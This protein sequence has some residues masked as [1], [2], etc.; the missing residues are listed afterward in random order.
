MKMLAK[1]IGRV[2]SACKR[3]IKK[4]STTPQPSEIFEHVDKAVQCGPSVEGLDDVLRN[5][6]WMP[7]TKM[8]E[9][10]CA[11][12]VSPIAGLYEVGSSIACRYPLLIVQ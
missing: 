9:T 7:C 1:F 3:I 10:S 11:A 5:H 4:Q 8:T 2:R 12:G 6:P